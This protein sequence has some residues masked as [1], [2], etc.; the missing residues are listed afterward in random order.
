MFS[1]SLL[2]LLGL[3]HNIPAADRATVEELLAECVEEAA[4]GGRLQAAQE[5]RDFLSDFLLD[6]EDEEG[7][8][9]EEDD[10]GDNGEDYDDDYEYE[11]Y[12][13]NKEG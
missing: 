1:D 5:L 12:G 2:C 3:L 10:T 11:D 4:P 7:D 8:E 13:T 6:E 9:D